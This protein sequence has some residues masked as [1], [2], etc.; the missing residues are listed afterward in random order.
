MVREVARSPPCY[1]AAALDKSSPRIPRP[2]RAPSPWLASLLSF[3]FPGAGQLYAGRRRAAAIFA[4]PVLLLIVF[5]LVQLP[6]GIDTFAAQMIAPSFALITLVIIV[7]LGVWRLAAIGHAFRLAPAT[8]RRRRLRDRSPRG[9]R[10]RGRCNARRCRLLRVGPS[11][12]P[13]RRSSSRTVVTPAPA[14][15]ASPSDMASPSAS[16]TP[17]FETPAVTLPPP[18]NWVTF[19]LTGIDSGHDRTHALTDTLM[20][21]SVN[22]DTKQAVMLSIP[23]DT[24]RF[25]MYSG[26]TYYGKINSLLSAARQNPASVSGWLDR[27]PGQGDQLPDRDPDQ[28]LRGDQPRRLPIDGRPPRGS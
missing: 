6:G 22:R 10:D 19:L 13:E 8:A 18:T 16:A 12:T 7:L 27:D 2:H 15:V 9:R 14:D 25:P 23:R 21:V 5:V 24:A 17:G 11:M 26:G 28:L 4:V 1:R 3:L 20:V